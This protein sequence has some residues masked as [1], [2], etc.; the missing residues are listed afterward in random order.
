MAL[1]SACHSLISCWQPLFSIFHSTFV[2]PLLPLYS[3]LAVCLPRSSYNRN[4]L[5]ASL[6]ISFFCSL[7]EFRFSDVNFCLSI[8]AHREN[9]FKP[10]L[11]YSRRRKNQTVTWLI[12]NYLK[13]EPCSVRRY[14]NGSD[15][16]PPC[17]LCRKRKGMVMGCSP[18]G[19]VSPDSI[20]LQNK[21]FGGSCPLY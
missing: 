10:S 9:I 15:K 20:S 21:P 16:I 14:P 18:V 17:R 2:C 5:H 3:K 8:S 19:T 7:S 11:S 13:A 4:W 12:F 6:I 1:I